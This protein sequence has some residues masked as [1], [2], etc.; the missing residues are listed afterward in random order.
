MKPA[1]PILLPSTKITTY[2]TRAANK[3]RP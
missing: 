2:A 1:A 3:G